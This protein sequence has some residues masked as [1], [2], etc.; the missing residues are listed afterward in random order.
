MD[1]HLS[2]RLPRWF[3]S[4]ESACQ[5]GDIED[6]GSIPGLGSTSGVEMATPPILLVGKSYGQKSLV[7]YG[8]WGRK[9]SNM[10]KCYPRKEG[11]G[12]LIDSGG[13]GVGREKYIIL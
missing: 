5:A 8:S 10:T 1:L 7:G 11:S 12:S 2:L 4:K 6:E 13:W 3:S 9:K